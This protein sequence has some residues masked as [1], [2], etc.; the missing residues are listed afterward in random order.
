[1]GGQAQQPGCEGWIVSAIN[2]QVGN[3]TLPAVFLL[4]AL[5][6]VARLVRP[7]Q[8]Y[9]RKPLV[10]GNELEFYRRLIRAYPEGHVFPQVA[11]AALVEPANGSDKAKLVAFRQISQ[12][13]CDYIITDRRLEVLVVVE[14]DDSTHDARRDAQ[15]DRRLSSAG[16]P[17]L[18]WNSREKP[19]LA[20]IRGTLL[21]TIS[22]NK[23]GR[24]A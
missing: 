2:S 9:R 16:I 14:L 15:R 8:G 22:A 10:T 23:A 21:H 7:Q 5:L 18:R 17:T 24:S 13:R 6:A 12:K 1:M 4:A 19:D 20:E 11:M 3:L